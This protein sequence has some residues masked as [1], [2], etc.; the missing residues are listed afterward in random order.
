MVLHSEKL[1]E[2]GSINF[3][4]IMCLHW[5]LVTFLCKFII[6]SP[7]HWIRMLSGYFSLFWKRHVFMI[8]KGG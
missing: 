6:K 5:Q 7:N 3:V 2:L 1:P 4:P 8:V